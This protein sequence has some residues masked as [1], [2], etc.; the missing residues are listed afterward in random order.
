M[1]GVLIK[2]GNSDIE[3]CIEGRWYEEAQRED[4]L[5][6]SEYRRERSGMDPSLVF[7]EGTSPC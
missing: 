2:R 1:T 6:P 7:S 4:D 5:R 3:T